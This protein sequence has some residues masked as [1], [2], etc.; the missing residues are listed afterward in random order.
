LA[1]SVPLS[2]FTSR[3]GGGSA[4]FVRPRETFWICCESDR[5]AEII[6]DLDFAE[7]KFVA[8]LSSCS[9]AGSDAD[10]R[11]LP[12]DLSAEIFVEWFYEDLRNVA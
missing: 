5:Q 11:E 2:R 7:R 12:R 3:V 10:E 8:D 6:G 4:F 1:R 9:F